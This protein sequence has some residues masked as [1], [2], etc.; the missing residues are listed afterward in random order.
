MSK[1]ALQQLR[2]LCQSQLSHL[3]PPNMFDC[4]QFSCQSLLRAAKKYKKSSKGSDHWL[5]SELA[6][7]P[8]EVLSPIADAVDLGIVMLSWAHQM[9]LEINP[10]LG[11]P[12]GGERTISLTP[13]I[14][15]LWTKTRK[16]VLSGWQNDNAAHY[17]AAK[18]GSS[19][20]KAAAWRA[21]FAEVHT[22]LGS[23]V[24]SMLYDFEKVL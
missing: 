18:K 13:K 16:M 15:R 4:D 8:D 6:N 17:N 14:Y 12:G 22:A 24:G 20:L 11:K 10:E 9:L 5:A 2:E 1:Q 7:L 19:A 21:L 23:T 3:S